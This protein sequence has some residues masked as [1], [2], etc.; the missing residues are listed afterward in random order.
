MNSGFSHLITT[1]MKY[2]TAETAVFNCL[3]LKPKGYRQYWTR[4]GAQGCRLIRKGCQKNSNQLLSRAATRAPPIFG[5]QGY[6]S[7][8]HIRGM[9][10]LPPSLSI[11]QNLALGALPNVVAL[12]RVLSDD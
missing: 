10:P 8:S 7:A 2:S 5:R 1:V 6:H 4:S 9:P 12:L 11:L 3:N